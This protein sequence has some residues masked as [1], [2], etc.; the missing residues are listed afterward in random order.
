MKTKKMRLRSRRRWIGKSLLTYHEVIVKKE[1]EEIVSFPKRFVYRM[2][3]VA[4]HVF[5]TDYTTISDREDCEDAF[6][7]T[8]I[9]L[10]REKN[11]QERLEML[12]KRD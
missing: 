4:I 11:G 2:M 10:P 6:T 8:L 5:I 1:A 7:Q 12:Q 3:C 9:S